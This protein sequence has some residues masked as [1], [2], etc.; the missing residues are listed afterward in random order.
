MLQYHVIKDD[1]P[2]VFCKLMSL[3]WWGFLAAA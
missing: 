2:V 1:R 3:G